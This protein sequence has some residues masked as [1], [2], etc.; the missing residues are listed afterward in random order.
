MTFIKINICTAVWLVQNLSL[1][2]AALKHFNNEK[3]RRKRPRLSFD[4]IR[5]RDW[6]PLPLKRKSE[7]IKAWQIRVVY[8]ILLLNLIKIADWIDFCS[9]PITHCITLLWG[10]DPHM[11]YDCF[12]FLRI[13]FLFLLF[14]TVCIAKRIFFFVLQFVRVYHVFHRNT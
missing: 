6:V 8:S 4:E 9:R 5:T 2:V 7:S 1:F 10:F 14:Q 3:W 11:S 12:V 13:S